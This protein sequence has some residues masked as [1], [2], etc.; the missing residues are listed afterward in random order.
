MTK[1]P[2]T[3]TVADL[4]KFR[5]LAELINECGDELVT[6]THRKPDGTLTKHV[7]VPSAI[8]HHIKGT[9]RGEKMSATRAVTS[10]HIYPIFDLAKVEKDRLADVPVERRG[11]RSIDLSAITRLN[12]GNARVVWSE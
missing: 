5:Y 7:F 6:A 11:M 4:H 2:R 1:I 9:E 12:T 8:R 3:F 10:P